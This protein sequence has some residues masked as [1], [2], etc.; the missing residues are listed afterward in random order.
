[1]LDDKWHATVT[2]RIAG[3]V[4]ALTLALVAASSELGERYAETVGELDAEL[5]RARGQGCALTW[6]RWG[7]DDGSRRHIGDRCST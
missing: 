1:M 5:E 7:S 4:N 2:G 6:L 3:E